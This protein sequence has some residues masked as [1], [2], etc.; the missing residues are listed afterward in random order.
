MSVGRQPI[1]VEAGDN[2][3]E[4][5]GQ[6]KKGHGHMAIVRDVDNTDETKDPIRVIKGVIT[7][8]DIAEE[9]L[10]EEI[11]DETDVYVN[12]AEASSNSV[13]STPGTTPDGRAHG[14]TLSGD[15]SGPRSARS[16]F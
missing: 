2:L 1:F 4:V 12:V 9:I 7:L 13:E 8:E 6:F 3:G 10:G 16:V 14:R 5:L 15:G 11:V